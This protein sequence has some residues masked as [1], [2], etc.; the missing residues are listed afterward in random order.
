MDN[1]RNITGSPIAG[2][3]PHELVDTR[4]LCH[5]KPLPTRS[6]APRSGSCFHPP[7]HTWVCEPVKPQLPAPPSLT[8]P[9]SARGPAALNAAITNNGA[10]NAALTNLPRKINIGIS[11]SRDDY[12]HCHIND[13][14]LKVRPGSRP[15]T[16]AGPPAHG[17][18]RLQA[19][20][21]Q[22]ARTGEHGAAVAASN[23]AKLAG[24]W[25]RRAH[26]SGPEGPTNGRAT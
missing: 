6:A 12:A 11:N 15:P 9:P 16:T 20:A 8:A 17:P 2:I 24:W 3:D 13:V 18:S 14:G 7:F 25:A 1:V 10:G 23:A 4:P 21:W 19:C 22:V 26:S 5:G